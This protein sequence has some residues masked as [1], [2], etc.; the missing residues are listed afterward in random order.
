MYVAPSYAATSLDKDYL[1]CREN[2]YSTGLGV[3]SR[4]GIP[5][6]VH[7]GVYGG[8]V[9]GEA[10]WPKGDPK[11]HARRAANSVHIYDGFP[12][13]GWL[14]STGKCPD[15]HRHRGEGDFEYRMSNEAPALLL[16][17]WNRGFGFMINTSYCSKSL[18]VSVKQDNTDP[19]LPV[20]TICTIAAIM[21][22][23]ELYCAYQPVNKVI[24][25]H[26]YILFF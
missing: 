8:L 1:R 10:N 24:F 15:C 5:P 2:I 3:F 19:H 21:P 17:T 25:M 18:N 9:K 14:R 13:R 16:E 26:I 20:L 6:G 4:V 12:L 7:I 23:D 11:T 22:G